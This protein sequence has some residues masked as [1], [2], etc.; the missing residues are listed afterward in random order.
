[1]Y[2]LNFLNTKPFQKNPLI[3][4]SRGIVLFILIIFKLKKEIQFKLDLII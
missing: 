1:M 4:I 2:Y 3:I